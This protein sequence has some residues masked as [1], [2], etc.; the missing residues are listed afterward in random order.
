[1]SL[2]QQLIA[3]KQVELAKTANQSLQRSNKA[4]RQESYKQALLDLNQA[5][6]EYLVQA[7]LL[8]FHL[9]AGQAKKVR[10]KKDR[11]RVFKQHGIDYAAID[12]AETAQV[13]SW[14]AQ[15]IVY[16]DAIV[17]HDLDNTFP[18][19]KEGFPMVQFDN[20]YNILAEDITVH[21][22]EVLKALVQVIEQ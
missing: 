22:I 5:F 4:Q 20:A 12:G 9:N 13:L 18:F 19:W 1:M 7:V 2:E 6:E 8:A 17:T 21:F 10:Y 3:L 15:S 11:I 14:I 16:E